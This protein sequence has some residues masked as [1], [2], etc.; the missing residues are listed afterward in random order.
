MHDQRRPS[1][2][3][4]DPASA[5][6]MPEDGP[7]EDAARYQRRH[8]GGPSARPTRG[9]R[10]SRRIAARPRICVDAGAR[11]SGAAAAG[12]HQS[13]HERDGGDG[14]HYRPAPRPPDPLPAALAQPRSGDGAGF[15][16]WNRAGERRPAIRVFLHDQARR[17]GHGLV[18][19]AV[20]HR[21]AR[22]TIMGLVQRRAGR[23]LSIHT[24]VIPATRRQRAKRYSP[25]IAESQVPVWNRTF[26]PTFCFMVRC[27]LCEGGPP[28][29]PACRALRRKVK[30]PQPR[31]EAAPSSRKPT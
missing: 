15:R 22:W 18:D 17:H 2:E 23:D 25:T 6:V 26:V 24:A 8:R 10:S 31:T 1:G 3:R 4:G 13:C 11:R 21:S 19:L 28:R 5:R 30:P 29:S 16:H 27:L 14:G 9:A 20:D 12:D 7:T